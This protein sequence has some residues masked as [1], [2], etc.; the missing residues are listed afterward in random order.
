M[1]ARSRLVAP[2]SS[3]EEGGRTSQ[4]PLLRLARE[5]GVLSQYR[6]GFR[7]DRRPSQ[8]S[9]LAVLQALGARVTEPGSAEEEIR[10]VRLRRWSRIIAP[11]TVCWEG[12]RPLFMLRFQAADA[13]SRIE[14]ALQ[15]E[16]GVAA[17]WAINA[18]DMEP[19][20]EMH[21]DGV[22]FAACRARI[23]GKVPIGYHTLH[24]RLDGL[25]AKSKVISAPRQATGLQR[26]WGVF[27]PLYSLHSEHSPGAGTFSELGHVID[28]VQDLGGGVVSTLPL[29]ASFLD[30]PFAPSPYT[31]VSRRYWNEFY[32]DLTK[33]P[34]WRTA[35]GGIGSA[36]S[37][38]HVDYRQLMQG[39]RSALA[40]CAVELRG[41]RL[42]HFDDYLEG[43]ADLRHYAAYRAALERGQRGSAPFDLGDR[44]CR[45]H[46]YAQWIAG[47]QIAA[48]SRKAA[49]RGPGLYLDL[50][51][52]VHPLGYD[53]HRHRD[54][55]AAGVAGGAPP[56]RFFSKG[57][58]WG[59]AP[60][61]PLRARERGHDYF[62]RSVRHHV[63]HA[64]ILRIDHLMGFHRLFWI[65][66]GFDGDQGAYVRYPADELYAIA[67]LESRRH[68]TA[69]VGEDLG[70]VPAYVRRRMADHGLRRTYVAQF[71]FRNDPG[72]AVSVPPSESVAAV[73]THDTAMFSAF[74]TGSDIEDQID[75]GL[76]AADHARDALDRRAGLREALAAYLES[77]DGA[78]DCD[79]SARAVLRA[80]L[81]LLAASPAECVIVSLEDLWG[82]SLPQNT[83][84][85]DCERP[86]W[87][88][89]SKLS[90]EQ[91]R[92]DPRVLAA[93]A[94]V[95]SRRVDF[96]SHRRWHAKAAP[97][98]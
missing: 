86:N 20:R 98:S 66:D 13:G 39:K 96:R 78:G 87:S 97:S 49:E 64:G 82:E 2:E 83:P 21:V 6:D 63:R 88:R 1:T 30:K 84:G 34:E 23:P 24:V 74:W 11:V 62:I 53:A 92:T 81:D 56:D 37:G 42:R 60:V 22:R 50:P 29:L 75:V 48:L 85:T 43:A 35:Y 3:R 25:R 19:C 45:Y 89:R 76:L 31:P 69:L 26:T 38:R 10:R 93:L 44:V 67:C 8:E 4:G 33:V 72:R 54:V 12:R 80:V 94:R 16:D 79:G 71:E 95:A 58:N 59:F 90:F 68:G 55:F 36:P 77:R 65:P 73:N 14:F 61:N 18:G 52:G 5:Y 27:I 7:R 91:F 40:R 28:W 41:E 9:L 70:T 32:V 57:Q 51:L 47:G 17:S 15:R 46:A